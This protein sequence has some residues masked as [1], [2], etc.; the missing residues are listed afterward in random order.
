MAYY[1]LSHPMIAQL[2]PENGTYKNGFQ[3]GKAVE[4][5]VTPNYNEAS[6]YGDNE[7]AEYAKEFKDADVTVGVT[8]LPLQSLEIMFGHKVNS[9]TNDV[10]FGS[11]DTANNVG[12]GFYASESTNG[13]TTY[14]A[15][16]LPKVKF[17]EAEES[18]TTKGD[19][20]EFKSPSISGKA[21]PDTNGNWKYKKIFET[22]EEA[23]EWLKNKAGMATETEGSNKQTENESEQE[24]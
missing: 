15:C 20:I 8:T 3:C 16:F 11:G 12:Y 2:D 24:A 19:S 17:T 13:K 21:A 6:L 10:E 18:Y 23:V 14:V 7:L 22:E 9:L 5:T 4:T 1:G